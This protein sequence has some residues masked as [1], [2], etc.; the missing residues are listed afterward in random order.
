VAGTGDVAAWAVYVAALALRGVGW[1]P[2]LGRLVQY[3]RLVGHAD[4]VGA[5]GGMNRLTV[6]AY[7]H[8]W[9]EGNVDLRPSTRARYESS[10]RYYV[11]AQPLCGT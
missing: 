6:V 7:A 5:C 4:C 11:L 9:L 1:G 2:G 8:Q 10:L 3:L